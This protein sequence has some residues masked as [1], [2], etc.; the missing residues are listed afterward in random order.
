VLH[1]VIDL[2]ADARARVGGAVAEPR[3]IVAQQ[4]RLPAWTMI[5]GNSLKLAKTGDA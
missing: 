5:G 3:G 1:A 4:S 2:D